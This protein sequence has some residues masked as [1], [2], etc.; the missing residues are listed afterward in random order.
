MPTRDQLTDERVRALIVELG[1]AGIIHEDEAGQ[2]TATREFEEAA[3]VRQSTPNPPAVSRAAVSEQTQQEFQQAR[4]DSDVQTQL[5]L[6]WHVVTGR[7][8]SG[9]G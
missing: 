5:D 8:P 1:K 3:E 9:G 6:L 2:L 7:D 4:T